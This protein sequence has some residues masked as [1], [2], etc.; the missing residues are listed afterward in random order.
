[1]RV[2]MTLLVRDEADIVRAVVEHHLAVG[3]DMIVATDNGSIDG[4]RETL[5]EY[6]RGGRVRVVDEPGD[7]YSQWVWVTRMAR[8]AAVD[9][10][11]DWVLHADAD[12]F[13]CPE[14]PAGG[15]KTALA[16]VP[17]DCNVAIVGR[18]NFPPTAH[19][20]GPF[21]ERLV[22]R[23]ECSVNAL[24][25]PLAGKVCHRADPDV[26]IAQGNHEI[27]CE[28]LHPWTGTMPVTILHFPVRTY[29]QF[30]RKIV[31]GGRA[32]GRNPS[33]TPWIGAGWRR[34]YER[35]LAGDLRTYYDHQI[36]TARDLA[37]GLASGRYVVDRRLQRFCR[38]AGLASRAAVAPG[39]GSV[40][41]TLPG[42]SAVGLAAPR[43]S[44]E[45]LLQSP[46]AGID[47]KLEARL[48]G[49]IDGAGASLACAL[50]DLRAIAVAAALRDA[51]RRGVQVRIVLDP[52]AAVAH[53]LTCA[54]ALPAD[55]GAGPVHHHFIV[56]D[57]IDVWTGSADPTPESLHKRDADCLIIRSAALAAR[58]LEAF[59]A[60]TAD[61]SEEGSR[62]RPIRLTDGEAF[63]AFAP[64]DAL[65]LACSVL[66]RAR[67]VR[68]MAP[69]T[70][71]PLILSAVHSARTAGAKV[72]D[73]AA[74]DPGQA[75][76][77]VDRAIVLIGIGSAARE[78]VVVLRSPSVAAQY[79]DYV[80]RLAGADRE[81]RQGSRPLNQEHGTCQR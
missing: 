48:V 64:G 78:D 33:L 7:D 63:V 50:H 21:F 53:E 20:H 47:A 77:V 79:D 65:D 29:A 37:A 17:E 55:F 28:D 8:L 30:E 71:D 36:P 12:E 32:Y 70:S 44:V 6:A 22:I 40:R 31:L 49:F 74:A 13:W 42:P 9:H 5:D 24:G 59:G 51:V 75:L 14:Q 4:T 76:I 56:R 34:L 11:A 52:G 68:V 57:A 2:V 41:A 81:D 27:H 54:W 80:D 25:K 26:W 39:C 61:V 19:E 72:D 35:Y 60:A 73:H 67:T 43:T 3:V 66:D 23:D 69:A 46:R 18:R 15:L 10:G 16:A 38:K 1:M 58:Y 45:A 62:S